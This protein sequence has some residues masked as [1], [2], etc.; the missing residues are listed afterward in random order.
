MHLLNTP[1][2]SYIGVGLDRASSHRKSLEWLQSRRQAADARTLV[3]W[4]WHIAVLTGSDLGEQ[5]PLFLHNTRDETLLAQAQETVFLGQDT[6]QAVFAADFS[7]LDDA[8]DVL[9]GADAQLADLRHAVHTLQPAHSAMLGFGKA[10]MHWHE[11]HRYCGRCGQPT[12][13]ENGGHMRVCVDKSCGKAHFPRV[14][15][16]IIVLVTRTDPATGESLC[17]LASHHRL[18][19][20]VYTTLAGFVDPGESLEE[21]VGREVYEESGITLKSAQYQGS[22]PWPFPS[23]IM[24]GFFATAATTEISCDPDELVDARWFRADDV[25]QAGDWGDESRPLW[26]PRRDSIARHLISTWLSEQP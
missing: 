6:Q 4:R 12:V 1:E 18:P 19:S 5:A 9:T 23:Q 3:Y 20:R 11:N 10:L 17:L 25:R 13:S 14:D 21:A 7:H 16:A 26:L 15:P 8:Q 22:Q 24:L 2:F